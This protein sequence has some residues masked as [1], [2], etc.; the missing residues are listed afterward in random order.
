[1]KRYP[2][3]KIAS[4]G[5]GLMIVLAL[6]FT[7]LSDQNQIVQ[8]WQKTTHQNTQNQAFK[9]EP[10]EYGH[11]TAD[12][13]NSQKRPTIARTIVGSVSN[14][15]N[16][17]PVAHAEV[18]L[19]SAENH[20]QDPIAVGNS[21]ASGDFILET[22]A[23]G[24]FFVV[25][26]KQ[27]FISFKRKVHVAKI[28][29]EQETRSVGPLHLK[30]SKATTLRITYFSAHTGKELRG[31]WARA[32]LPLTL[33]FPETQPGIVECVL[34]PEVWS[35]AVAAE[36]HAVKMVNFDLSDGRD[37]AIEV[38]L[39]PAGV[40]YGQVKDEV[41]ER[42]PAAK[43]VATIRGTNLIAK[44]DE[45][46]WYR[47]AHVPTETKVALEATHGARKAYLRG[48]DLE[49][50]LEK[51][52][53][54]TLFS[55]GS[56]QDQNLPKGV[57]QGWVLDE[58][59][60]A[61]ENAEVDLAG[62]AGRSRERL[63]TDGSGFFQTE[64]NATQ[65]PFR[66]YQLVVRKPSYGT[67]TKQIEIKPSQTNQVRLVLSKARV[68]AGHVLDKEMQAIPNVAIKVYQRDS[69]EQ[70]MHFK[71]ET[72]TNPLGFFRLEGLQMPVS[73]EFIADG[74]Q[75]KFQEV[76]IGRE[77]AVFHLESLGSI[78]GKVIFKETGKPVKTF[79]VHLHNL[80]EFKPEA[81][82]VAHTFA[83]G[84]TFQSED[85]T[86]VINGL[87]TFA[88]LEIGIKTKTHSLPG[89]A[90][91]FIGPSNGAEV[92]TFEL[93]P[94]E[95]SLAGVVTDSSG[96]TIPNA[97]VALY[98][99]AIDKMF[100]DTLNWTDRY[101]ENIVFQE[102]AITNQQGAFRFKNLPKG[103]NYSLEANY[104]GYAAGHL[105]IARQDTHH[106]LDDLRISLA[107]E[108]QIE[109]VLAG[110]ELPFYLINLKREQLVTDEKALLLGDFPLTF[111]GLTPGL[112]TATLSAFPGIGQ[113]VQRIE[114]MEV[115]L[116]EGA[117]ETLLF[118]ADDFLSLTG[119]AMVGESP[120]A[121]RELHLRYKK[122]RQGLFIRPMTYIRAITDGN[123]RFQF[124]QLKSGHYELG[125]VPRHQ[126]KTQQFFWDRV[127]KENRIE[128]HL[129]EDLDE[130]FSF[131]KFSTLSGRLVNGEKVHTVWLENRG[132]SQ[133]LAQPMAVVA[134]NQQFRLVDIAPGIYHLY[135]IEGKNHNSRVILKDL[136]V[137][138]DGADLDLGE[139]D[140]E[141][142]ARLRITV[143][144][145]TTD[146]VYEQL[147][148]AIFSAEGPLLKGLNNPS[149]RFF[150]KQQDQPHE[151]SRLPPGRYRLAS[152][153]AH[154]AWVPAPLISRFE[155]KPDV[156]QTEVSIWLQPTTLLVVANSAGRKSLAAQM[157]NLKTG[158]RVN[159]GVDPHNL[160]QL[161]QQSLRFGVITSQGIVARGFDEGLWRLEVDLDSGVQL[162]QEFQLEKGKRVDLIWGR[163]KQATR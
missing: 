26:R 115:H 58:M 65:F 5:I 98:G 128:F 160:Q 55:T 162:S 66:Y 33:P 149:H 21:D 123:G 132:D 49:G 25:A 62:R 23:I 43:V 78:H 11:S 38:Y 89:P 8:S 76:S 44:S 20:E 150:W 37:R 151:V 90:S 85:G 30:L 126:V 127:S 50:A 32:N 146:V 138:N 70:M 92:Q 104:E 130:T 12:R 48:I 86:F 54:L 110:Y 1:M 6:Y 120:A 94:M 145:T 144:T 73:L 46:G 41:G 124:E 28:N 29:L 143:S 64:V 53:D 136:V 118:K 79:T 155:I 163:K 16:D 67:L 14:I 59:G 147:R 77:D 107:R 42:L 101:S 68:L 141:P 4:I 134:P 83:H 72:E 103:L 75:S 57:L 122:D 13:A 3:K 161:S 105:R 82:S 34:T 152:L 88:R 71:E 113:E 39:N 106:G 40:L 109:I 116:E 63:M 99:C 81:G 129:E 112:Y 114:K 47:L 80:N 35:L 97:R 69:T 2:N 36:N 108:S 10:D 31:C 153:N 52:L 140:V 74:Y 133:A 157:V 18:L 102:H 159:L 142:D 24:T 119:L 158:E 121:Y 19:I 15:Q 95:T 148:F 100:T 125:L 17:R 137:P 22:Q 56:S 139:I 91:P 131:H 87:K 117:S 9:E 27:G 111:K 135:A 51:R 96:Q 60:D 45:A 154:S 84:V 61:I 7:F 93:E 156:E